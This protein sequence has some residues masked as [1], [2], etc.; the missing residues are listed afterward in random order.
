MSKRYIFPNFS[1]VAQMEEG[2]FADCF[3]LFV[4]GWYSWKFIEPDPYICS[5]QHAK[6]VS[7][8]GHTAI[9][10]SGE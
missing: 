3:H 1:D 2:R 7:G 10:S 8:R 5:L 6:H 4:H 9:D